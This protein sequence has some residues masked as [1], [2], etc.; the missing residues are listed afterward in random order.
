MSS[1]QFKYFA[2][3]QKNAALKVGTDAMLLGAFCNFKNSETI[4]DIGTGTGVLALMCAQRFS[5]KEI[6]ALEI[7]STACLDAQ[8]NFSNSPFES[9]ITLLQTSLQQFVTQKKYDGIICNPPYFE[10]STKNKKYSETLARH[11][12][13]LN[14]NDLAENITRLLSNS[15][16]ATIILPNIEVDKFEQLC[17]GHSLNLISE[18]QLFG[19]RNEKCIR[20]IL[21]FSFQNI[22][23][24]TS[25]F[26]IREVDGKYS[27]EYIELTKEFHN[28]DVS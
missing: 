9:N 23:K 8:I 10:N 11:T 15:G 14:F 4:L 3:I 20:C 26:V 27:K 21:T 1:F 17:K 5:P 18:I 13:E 12:D 24:E 7:D 2:I 22:E 25:D 6:D 28:R 16:K 19:K